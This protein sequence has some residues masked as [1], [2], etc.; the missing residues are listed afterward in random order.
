VLELGPFAS[1][2]GEPTKV[3]GNA[4]DAIVGVVA[5]AAPPDQMPIKYH[6]GDNETALAKAALAV[7]TLACCWLL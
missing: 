3:V 6:P 2:I 7:A 5:V 4:E 1:T